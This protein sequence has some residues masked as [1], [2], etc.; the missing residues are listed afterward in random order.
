V[1]SATLGIV[2]LGRI[3]RQVARRALGFDMRV[4]YHNRHRREDAEAVLG[5]RYASFD[6]LLAESDYVMLTCPLTVE[7]K[8]LIDARALAKM[9]CTA[10]LVNIA[11]GPVVDT[12]ALLEA[13]EAGQIAAAA[14]DV[15]DPEPLP[16]GHRLLE[17]PNVVIVPHLG[18]A[19]IE[20]RRKMAEISVENL[21]AGLEGRPLKFQV[22]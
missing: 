13:L 11:R 6:D 5:V 17:L 14:L 15:T 7:T 18:S 22:G 2:G 16:R 1:H 12:Q 10:T 9:K 8:R 4:L 3:G 20:T 21:L 19:T